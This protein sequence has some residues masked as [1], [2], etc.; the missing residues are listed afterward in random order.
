MPSW[1]SWADRYLCEGMSKEEIAGVVDQKRGWWQYMARY[2]LLVSIRPRTVDCTGVR[3]A[4]AISK[5]AF[6]C[7][8][9]MVLRPSVRPIPDEYPSRDACL[10]NACV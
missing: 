6:R 5:F 8:P 9:R 2:V 7:R 1:L 3:G 10:D 4:E